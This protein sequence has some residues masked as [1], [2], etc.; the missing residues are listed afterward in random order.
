MPQLDG[1]F[2][3]TANSDKNKFL[4]YRDVVILVDILIG[5]KFKALTDVNCCPFFPVGL[6]IILY[7]QGRIV[8]R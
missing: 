2:C 7:D 5:H 8:T 6:D 3:I 1:D 4:Y